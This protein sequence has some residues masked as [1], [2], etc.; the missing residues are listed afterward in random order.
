M[1]INIKTAEQVTV[2]ELIGDIDGGTA[3]AVQA[4]ILPLA[5]PGAR[6][7]LDMTQ[8][9]YMSSAGLRMLL[10]SYRQISAKG[11]RIV[12]VGLSEEIQDTMSVTGFLNFFVHCD[13]LDE[14]LKAVE[15]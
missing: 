13:T 10:A 1:E 6:I 11:G 9:P 12:L 2:V 14:G 15:A 4:Q 3:P 8:V 7:V 5:T